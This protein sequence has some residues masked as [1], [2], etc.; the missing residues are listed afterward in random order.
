MCAGARHPQMFVCFH[1]KQC[2]SCVG[3]CTKFGSALKY[4]CQPSVCV[5]MYAQMCMIVCLFSVHVG[6]VCVHFF[7]AK[8]TLTLLLTLLPIFLSKLWPV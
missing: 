2:T 7:L 5:K 3:M 1:R 8:L 6:Y 4:V